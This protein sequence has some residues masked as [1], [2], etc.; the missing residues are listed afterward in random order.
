MKNFYKD[1]YT[2]HKILGSSDFLNKKIWN[3][4]Y[5]N[6]YDLVYIFSATLTQIKGEELVVFTE[7]K[8][9]I[10]KKLGEPGER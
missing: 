8:S 10:S 7:K 6:I 3:V 9:K 4:T 1:N 2:S 5:S